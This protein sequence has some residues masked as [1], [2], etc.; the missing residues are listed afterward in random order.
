MHNTRGARRQKRCT[1][2]TCLRLSGPLH[3]TSTSRCGGEASGT[4]TNE[5]YPCPRQGHGSAPPGH[6]A[7]GHPAPVAQWIEQAPSK[8]LAAGS[9]P[10]GGA[11]DHRSSAR[12]FRRSICVFLVFQVSR[13]L[14]L[15]RE[16]SPD[17]TGQEFATLGQAGGAGC[18]VTL[19]S[20]W[21]QAQVLISGERLAVCSGASRE[22]VLSR[23]PQLPPVR[24][25]GA[26]R[27][28]DRPGARAAA[29]PADYCV[30]GLGPAR[31]RDPRCGPAWVR[32]SLRRRS[33]RWRC[34]AAVARGQIKIA[35]WSVAPRQDD[36]IRLRGPEHCRA[37]ERC[38]PA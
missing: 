10:A 31:A 37:A 24:T 29:P 12:R 1:I 5:P 18:P 8:R 25:G 26:L 7:H 4:R 6:Q 38:R 16:S 36:R 2:R 14:R 20:A 17:G 32:S 13:I 33:G 22:G 27:R 34:G 35:Q 30:C 28:P 21:P 3:R 23:P 9:S 15:H 19:P 11:S